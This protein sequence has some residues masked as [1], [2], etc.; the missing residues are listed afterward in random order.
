[1]ATKGNRLE[2]SRLTAAV[3][4][5]LVM[6]VTGAAF[7]QD[8]NAQQD[9]SQAP[10]QDQ[11]KKA[12]TLD[13][14]IVTGS[15]IPQ[16]QIETFKPVTVISAEDMK[17]RGFTDVT[18]ALS[19]S[20]FAT[21]GVQGNQESASFTQ[22][23]ET[24][25]LFGLNP[26]YTKYLIDGRPLADYPALYNGSDAFNNISGIPID[27]VERIEI[28]PGGQSSLYGS[29]AIAGVINI[30]LKKKLDGGVVSARFGWFDEGGGES[31]RYS[32]ADGFGSDD[33][34]FN[35]L[36]GAQF[37]K[38]D[39][40]WGYQRD[41]TRQFNTNGTM[42]LNGEI[43]HSPQTA[44][45]D[46]LVIGYYS[47]YTFQD[48]NDCAGVASMFGGTE[49]KTTRYN[50]PSFYCGSLYT[51][52]Y[53][54]LKNGKE[55]EQFYTHA[56]FD[57]NDNVQLYG[58]LLYNNE[59]VRYHIGSNFTWWGSS[60]EFGYYWDPNIGDF[61]QLQRAFSPED[62]GGWERSMDR[63]DSD[64]YQAD[65]GIRGTFGESNWDYDLNLSRTQYRL[66]E[67]SF[68]R[69]AGPI[70]A[71]F[72]DN[73][74]GTQQGT[75]Y[76]Y[77][78]FTPNYAAFYQLIPVDVFNSFTGH[79]SSRSYT[80]DTLVRAQLTN[81]SLF[82]MPGGDAGLAIAAEAGSQNWTYAPDA[83]LLDGE[84][85]GTTATAGAGHRTRYAVTSE[86]RLPIWDPLTVSVS[87]RYDKFTPTGAEAVS[88][89]TY[90]VGIEYR[91]IETLLFR[92]KYGTAFKAP[93]LPDQFQQQSGYYSTV[94]DYY[95]CFLHGY[96]PGEVSACDP[97]YSNRQY[98]GTTQGS[99]DLEPLTAKVWSAGVVWAPIERMSMAV[100]YH[101][102]DIKN[103]VGVQ[104]ASGL[105]LREYYCR[106]GQED[107]NSPG[108]QDA[109]SKITRNST[110]QITD[111][112][113]PKV[114]EA[115]QILNAVT[116]SF[117]YGFD[118]GSFGDLLFRFD[119]TDNL[120]QE[121]TAFVGDEPIN[122]LER[123]DWSTDPKTKANTSITWHK[124]K[125][126]STLYANYMGKTPNRMSQVYGNK[127]LCEQAAVL[128][129]ASGTASGIARAA[130]I[131]AQCGQIDSL[132]SHTTF[133]A[134]VTYHPTDSLE[135]SF[136][137]NNLTNK[138]P[139]KDD[140]YDG[141][142]GAPYNEFNYDVYGRAFYFEARYN[143]GKG[144]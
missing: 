53:R 73:I 32:I 16:T 143:F 123:G 45:R 141:L 57:I 100:D 39:P 23:A 17:T 122:L 72:N 99:I 44:S 63:A 90:S 5:A 97:R 126:S 62:M 47:S 27:L 144:E 34:R 88:K 25:S 121:Y 2:R 30:I 110:G 101:H 37:E 38:R 8:A 75:Y 84:I 43:V 124:D 29:D 119:Y 22:G 9:Q 137:V 107:I 67:T 33:G 24:N 108:C 50:R 35:I 80:S 52:G 13:K 133:N 10:A 94:T 21:G 3:F 93:T 118:I 68:A 81:A 69:L 87:G 120:K 61:M 136:L 109:L 7:A 46:V 139:P 85:W 132:S 41:L 20:S 113:T 74:L 78:V 51:P 4:A 106:T 125:W 64:S 14:V 142:S 131:R 129:E 130:N 18:E 77:P 54:T 111:I 115:Q 58:D 103:E 112:F 12:A 71:W 31:Q 138:M 92:G 135:L 28:L 36:L 59:S 11:A 102:W 42:A 117:N 116:A 48:P 55:S 82:S 65:A 98:F 91:P 114:N 76:G 79:T 96:S 140:T 70:N 6:P 15:L 86:L 19:K 104:N 83:R 127:E 89:P 40:I 66:N 134:S 105:A 95:Q 56:T 128:A 49:E 60:V 1:M 26:G